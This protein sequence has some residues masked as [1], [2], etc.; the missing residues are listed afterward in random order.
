[1]HA[2]HKQLHIGTCNGCENSESVIASN[3]AA[4]S[5]SPTYYYSGWEV[6]VGRIKG[7]TQGALFM[8]YTVLL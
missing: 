8:R 6:F 1:M 7:G 2:N 4:R 3:Y 5:G